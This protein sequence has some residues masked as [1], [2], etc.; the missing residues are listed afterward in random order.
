LNDPKI[1]A[2]I[3]FWTSP[4]LHSFSRPLRRSAIDSG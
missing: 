1:L 4:L 2:K 3:D